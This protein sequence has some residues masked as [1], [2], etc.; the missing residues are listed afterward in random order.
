[1][2][3]DQEAAGVTRLAG[4]FTEA[5]GRQP[6][7]VWAGPGRVNLI[8]E[9]TDYNDGFALPMALPHRVMVAARARGDDELVLRSLQQ[10]GS[11]ATVRGDELSPGSLTGWP[12][13]V[14][15]VWWALRSAGYAP[16]GAEM[17]VDSDLPAGSGLSSSAAL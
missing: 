4:E 1:M 12:G 17:L 5:F 7:G 9:H 10:A 16:G 11:S 6:Y 2:S 13:Y 3:T 8:G 14:A 15:G